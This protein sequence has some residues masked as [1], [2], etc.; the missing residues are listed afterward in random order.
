MVIE[1]PVLR[2]N[3][4]RLVWRTLGI[5]L[6]G[7]NTARVGEG[8]AVDDRR[9]STGREP[10]GSVLRGGELS[11]GWR[12][13]G[14]VVVVILAGRR[15][16]MRPGGGSGGAGRRLLEPPRSCPPAG[17]SIGLKVRCVLV[18]R[19]VGARLMVIGEVPGQDAAQVSFA[20]DE[21][22]VE[23]LAP[24]RTD[25]ALRERILPGAVR[26][27]ED[28]LDPHAL[29]AVAEL[30]AID[31]VTVAQEIGRADRPGTRRR[32]AGRSRQRWDAR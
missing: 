5:R 7:S 17:S 32:S 16:T 12:A 8:A 30:L 13:R 2:D 25:Q 24:D 19:E 11:A 3:L 23:T 1:S 21:N 29:H 15:G 14:S 31:L 28:F 22:V 26:R 9:L 27:R 4:V 20:Q 6:R 18:E 10:Y